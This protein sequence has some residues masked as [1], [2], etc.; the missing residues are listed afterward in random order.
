MRLQF[1]HLLFSIF[2]TIVLQNQFKVKFI[3]LK[4]KEPNN[5]FSR[6]RGKLERGVKLARSWS[7]GHSMLRNSLG[8]LQRQLECAKT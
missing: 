5:S 3:N 2:E 6:L 7:P 8:F 4:N 1:I